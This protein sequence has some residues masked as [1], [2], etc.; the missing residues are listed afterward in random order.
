[1]LAVSKDRSHKA[2]II[3]SNPLLSPFQFL[4]PNSGPE[5]GKRMTW[6]EAR[7]DDVRSR[8]GSAKQIATTR[9]N[10]LEAEY[11]GGIYRNGDEYVYRIEFAGNPSFMPSEIKAVATSGAVLLSVEITYGSIMSNKGDVTLPH[12]YRASEY[13][14]DQKEI[15]ELSATVTQ[16]EC[17]KPIPEEMFTVD[18][19]KVRTIIDDDASDANPTT[20]SLSTSESQSQGSTNV[21]PGAQ[22]LE[23]NS[24]AV[25]SRLMWMWCFAMLLIALITL[26][27]IWRH[28][29]KPNGK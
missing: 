18:S 23:P 8:L 2:G 6:S 20:A 3:Y 22:S 1:M 15:W 5:L 29:L 24:A 27:L 12:S 4:F 17:D 26:L 14:R 11:P 7:G 19:A 16:I 21:L 28:R 13:D 10:T 25:R 9:P